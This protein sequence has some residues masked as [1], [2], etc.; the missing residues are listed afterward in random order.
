MKP[1]FFT[2]ALF[3][4]VLMACSIPQHV[5]P[6]MRWSD[7]TSQKRPQTSHEIRY[8]EHE[9]QIV[10]V[11]VPKTD[12][13]YP[14]VLMIHGGCWQKEIADRTLMHYAAGA[15]RDEGF[16]VWNIE[17]RGV[18][19][20]GG[21]YPGTFQ[22]V[23][24]AIDS[25]REHAE[26]F[27][28][29][30]SNISAFGH[31]AGGHLAVWAAAR[32]NLSPTSELYV[33]TPLPLHG[34]INT[35]GLAD[36]EASAPVTLDDCLVAIMDN[37]TGAPSPERTNVLSDTSPAELLPFAATLINVNGERDHIAPPSLGFAFTEK[38]GKVKGQVE[39]VEIPL[40]GH[41]ELIAPGTPAFAQ[42]TKLLTK[43]AETNQGGRR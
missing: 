14:V 18:D 3:G 19:E 42:Q 41:V 38:V 22:D 25:M 40:A 4:A 39:Y 1:L 8:G 13:P 9:S 27:R 24:A 34:V 11:W 31:S 10:D 28:L 26:T 43:L 36:L 2:P 21:G 37:L 15:L 32:A 17:Y 33:D 20:E 5:D 7:L 23:G 29:D 30:L 16:A 6:V 35:G 12:G